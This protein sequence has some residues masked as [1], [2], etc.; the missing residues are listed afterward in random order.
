MFQPYTL[1]EGTYLVKTARAAVEHFLN[2]KIYYPKDPPAKLLRDN[3]GIFTTIE[4]L[5][6]GR[7]ELRGCIGYLGGYLNTL[8]AVIHSAIAACCR[9]PRFPAMQIDELPRVVFEVS[10]LSPLVEDVEIQVG[11]HGLFVKRGPYSGLLLPQVAVEH[12]WDTEEFLTNTCIKAWLPGDCWRD[13]KTKIYVYE[14]QIFRETAPMGSVY[15][16]DLAAEV[17]RCSRGTPLESGK[18][19]NLNI[20]YP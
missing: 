13:G 9:D 12:C 15:Q 10:I 19:N 4:T 11:R 3:Y 17:A 6:G 8:H 16:R 20:D 5:E 2:G 1:E 18:S 14:A 7:Y